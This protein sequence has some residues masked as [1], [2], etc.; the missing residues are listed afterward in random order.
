MLF[1]LPLRPSS[2]PFIVESQPPPPP[3]PVIITPIVLPGG[4][5]TNLPVTSKL[6]LHLDAAVGTETLQGSKMLSVW[7]NR[8]EPQSGSSL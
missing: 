4:S 5:P 3:P 7:R 1:Y 2:P 8:A 6:I